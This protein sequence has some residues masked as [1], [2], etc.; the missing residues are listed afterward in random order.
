MH[1]HGM[2]AR[3]CPACGAI[4]GTTPHSVVLAPYNRVKTIGKKETET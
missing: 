2:R 4:I 3:H 1:Q